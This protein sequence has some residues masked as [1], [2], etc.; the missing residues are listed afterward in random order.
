MDGDNLGENLPIVTGGVFKLV[1][2]GWLLFVPAV[3]GIDCLNVGGKFFN[4]HFA[5][6]LVSLAA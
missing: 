4:S 2:N 6:Q 3:G 5:A 1:E